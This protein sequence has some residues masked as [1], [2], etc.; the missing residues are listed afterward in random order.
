MNSDLGNTKAECRRFG[1]GLLRVH[2]VQ[3]LVL[4]QTQV[5]TRG[6]VSNTEGLAPLHVA[7]APAADRKT[8]SFSDENYFSFQIF[9]TLN[10]I[11]TR[12]NTFPA[13]LLV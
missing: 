7:A 9:P 10:I 3:D 11:N 6:D 1:V 2:H 13:K 12:N 5:P 4:V 8:K